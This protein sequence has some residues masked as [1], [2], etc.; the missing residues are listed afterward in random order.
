MNTERF[1]DRLSPL[2]QAALMDAAKARAV[3]L[4]REAIDDFWR[5]AAR[6]LRSAWHAVRSDVAAVHGPRPV[7]RRASR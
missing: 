3:E 5:A 4:R 2:E 7:A 6:G 1:H